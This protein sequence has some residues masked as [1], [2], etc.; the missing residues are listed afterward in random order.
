[1]NTSVSEANKLA[2][3]MVSRL[4]AVDGVTRV[5]CPPFTSL[6]TV[7]EIVAG[8]DISVGAQDLY[9]ESNGAFTGEISP[10]MVAEL[11]RY[12]ILGHSERRHILG[13]TNE[14]VAKKVEAA[15]GAG[16][17]PIVCVGETIGEREEGR[18]DAVVE[19]QTRQGL[20][21]I[22]LIDEVVIAY[23]PVWAIGTG[24]AATPDDAQS[25]MSVIR[26]ALGDRYGNASDSA[27]L[28][29]GGSVK[30][31]NVA[32]FMRQADVDGALVGGASLES[33]GFVELVRNA[34][35]AAR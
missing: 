35:A 30:A 31:D 7:A 10:A 22:D 14:D 2:S 26:G 9:F 1:M 21:R 18:A 6:A 16:L 19:G 8:T 24:R 23:E 3:A 34:A 11:C 29:Y 25:M 12:V 5:L 27:P 33:E 17:R 4:D 28:L 15:L 20:A 32:D 13:E